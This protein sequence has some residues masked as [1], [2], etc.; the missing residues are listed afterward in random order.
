M[1]R[2]YRSRAARLPPPPPGRA[3]QTK[4]QIQLLHALRTHALQF[5]QGDTM[6]LSYSSCPTCLTGSP[7]HVIKVSFV[8][9]GCAFWVSLCACTWSVFSR[10]GDVL[11]PQVLIGSL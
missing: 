5:N 7:W 2:F 4:V 8:G 6:I 11:V 3:P 9:A 10:W 1:R